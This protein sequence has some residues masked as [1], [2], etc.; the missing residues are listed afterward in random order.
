VGLIDFL[1][2]SETDVGI[3]FMVRTSSMFPAARRPTP[4]VSPSMTERRLRKLVAENLRLTRELK[5]LR[6]LRLWALQHSLTGLPNRR[7]FEERLD[8]ELVRWERDA[9]QCGAVLIVDVND[10]TRRDRLGHKRAEA[11]WLETDRV[12]RA[13]LRSCDVCSRTGGDEFMVLLPETG[14]GGAQQAMARLR[15]S[16][17]RAGARGDLPLGISISIG[18]SSWPADGHLV[19]S[20]I[21]AADAALAAERKTLASRARRRPPRARRPLALIK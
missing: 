7:L 3:R 11:A 14:H 6:R 2:R 9:S 19:S 13:A 8:E 17:M 16:V 5:E 4:V 21:Q 10:L 15:A 12:L 20:L 1:G 18:M